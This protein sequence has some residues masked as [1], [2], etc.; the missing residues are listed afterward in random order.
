M[1]EMELRLADKSG[2]FRIKSFGRFQDCIWIFQ[3]T[4]LLS[5]EYY[6]FNVCVDSFNFEF[7]L[8][9][10]DREVIVLKP[11]SL[12]QNH[13]TTDIAASKLQKLKLK[14]LCYFRKKEAS[15]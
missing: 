15:L 8:R 1:E 9:M 7:F 5:M 10:A 2:E 12:S 11:W 6:K 4:V 13:S 3:V 14:K